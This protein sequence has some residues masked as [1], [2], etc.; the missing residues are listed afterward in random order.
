MRTFQMFSIGNVARQCSPLG[1]IVIR[2]RAADNAVERGWRREGVDEKRASF[3]EVARDL[4]GK[5]RPALPRQKSNDCNRACR[6]ERRSCVGVSHVREM[7][8]CCEMRRLAQGRQ[9]MVRK[10][11]GAGRRCGNA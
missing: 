11:E 1:S 4:A 5:Q 6:V 8:R 3:V 9:D 7:G 2:L 10:S